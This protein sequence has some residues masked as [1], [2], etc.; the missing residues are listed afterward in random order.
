MLLTAY[1]KAVTPYRLRAT[2]GT[3]SY[4]DP[5]ESWATPDRLKLKGATVQD[6]STVETEGVTKRVIK[7]ETTLFAPGAVDVKAEDRIE[8]GDEVWRVDGDP[9]VKAG[10][11]SAVFTV[12]TLKRVTSGG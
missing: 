8:V 4:G 11:A 6:V 3:D 10:L 12:A 1:R 2:A 7:G 9:A 5:V